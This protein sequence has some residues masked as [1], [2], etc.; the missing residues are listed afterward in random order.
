MKRKV[1]PA[2]GMSLVRSFARGDELTVSQQR[3]AVRFALEEFAS[4]HPGRSVEIRVPW[5]GA[6]QA[7]DGPVHTRGTP[8]NV[9]EMDAQTWLELVIG[10]PASGSIKASGSRSNLEDF[11]PLFGPGQ[12]GE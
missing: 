9:V 4:R 5:A 1:D 10:K 7:I 6:V 2:A 3:M 12:L 11:L 8:P